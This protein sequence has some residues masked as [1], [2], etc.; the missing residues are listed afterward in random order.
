MH[1]DRLHGNPGLTTDGDHTQLPINCK[2]Q[3]CF[4]LKE[5]QKKQMHAIC[6]KFVNM[7][8]PIYEV[9]E[10]HGWQRGLFP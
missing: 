8:W 5:V 10:L 7:L 3:N 6:L 1:A 4:F 9:H 2:G